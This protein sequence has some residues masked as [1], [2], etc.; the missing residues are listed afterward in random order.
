MWADRYQASGEQEK[1]QG[2]VSLLFKRRRRKQF[3][4]N[5]NLYFEQ[6]V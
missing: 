5:V 1:D 3:F 6:I 2:M 4:G